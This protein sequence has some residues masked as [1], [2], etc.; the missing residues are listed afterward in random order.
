MPRTIEIT[1]PAERTESLLS[2]LDALDAVTG[3]RVQ[4]GASRKPP[5]DVI[6]VDVTNRALPAVIRVLAKAGVGAETTASFSTSEPL[7]L[8]S[9]SGAAAIANDTSDATWEE[10]EVV[11]GKNSNVTP[12]AAL[13]MAIAGV[14][15]TIGI[16]TNALHIVIGAMLIAPGF[17]PIVRMALGIVGR[18]PA[19]RRGLLHTPLAYLALAGGAAF[20]ALLLQALG[21][22]PLGTT[23]SSYLPEGVLVSYWTTLSVSSAIITF[24]A[25][26][27][28]AL[29]V[30]TNRAVLTVGVMVAV[31][32]VPGATI[33]AVALVVGDFDTAFTGVLRWITELVLILVASVLVL[34]W[35]RARVQKRD[36]LL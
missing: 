14:L 3:I 8:V 21:Q 15:A 32:L 16:A 7:S 4:Q 11:I 30:A 10:M 23:E 12:S 20:A 17:Q 36:A 27:A 19:W 34:A 22:S 29:L 35:K 33:A 24:T 2:A 28:G 9:S 31:A 5:G 13:V 1:V 25:G 26:A 6:T 18:S